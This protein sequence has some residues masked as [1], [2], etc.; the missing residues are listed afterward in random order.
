M[1]LV[2][3]GVV[4][5]SIA[6]HRREKPIAWAIVGIGIPLSFVLWG[7]GMMLISSFM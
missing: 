7:L 3:V 2:V 5:S 4:F 6:F 1:V